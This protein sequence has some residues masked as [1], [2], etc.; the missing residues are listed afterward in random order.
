[1]VNHVQQVHPNLVVMTTVHEK[2]PKKQGLTKNI[3]QSKMLQ[4]CVF[5]SYIQISLLILDET[6]VSNSRRSLN[7][8]DDKGAIMTESYLLQFCGNIDERLS[9][10][11]GRSEAVNKYRSKSSLLCS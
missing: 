11:N 10:A 7:K 1:M 6:G 8:Q 4:K 3:V 2:K 5:V 9:T